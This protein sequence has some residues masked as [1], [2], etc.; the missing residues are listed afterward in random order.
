MK[1]SVSCLCIMAAVHV[2]RQRDIGLAKARQK[3]PGVDEIGLR[4]DVPRLRQATERAGTTNAT[5]V[6][7]LGPYA[8]PLLETFEYDPESGKTYIEQLGIDYPTVREPEP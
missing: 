1:N 3:E 7:W 6:T 2:A 5:D 4:T 8:R